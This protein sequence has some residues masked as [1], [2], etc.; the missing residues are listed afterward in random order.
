MVYNI[1]LFFLFSRS[2]EPSASH[3]RVSLRLVPVPFVCN[4]FVP[5]KLMKSNGIII[6]RGDANLDA[7][8][9]TPRESRHV[10]YQTHQVKAKE[11]TFVCQ[12]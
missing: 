6:L 8:K 2:V 1:V 9:Y 10:E 5:Q 7:V 12:P 11:I 4:L 3:C